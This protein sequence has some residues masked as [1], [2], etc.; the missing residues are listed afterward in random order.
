MSTDI[1][2]LDLP[3]NASPYKAEEELADRITNLIHEYDGR[4]GLASTCG[5]LEIVK[6]DL[7]DTG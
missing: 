5:V 4:I 6:N 2:T 7:L 3:D 1:P